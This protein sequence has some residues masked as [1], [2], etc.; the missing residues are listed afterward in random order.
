MRNKRMEK[1]SEEK[2]LQRNE[3]AI[4]NARGKMEPERNEIEVERNNNTG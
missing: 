4:R 1:N 3:R 2:R